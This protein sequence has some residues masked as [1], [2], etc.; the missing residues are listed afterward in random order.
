MYVLNLSEEV[1][2]GFICNELIHS[3]LQIMFAAASSTCGV[4][5][6]VGNGNMCIALLEIVIKNIYLLLNVIMGLTLTFRLI[7]D[8]Q[9]FAAPLDQ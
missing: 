7:L 8:L 9:T 3:L 1:F 5:I 2:R 4:N 6:A